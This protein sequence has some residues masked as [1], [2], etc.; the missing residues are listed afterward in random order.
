MPLALF[1]R[2]I[3]KL[4]WNYYLFFCTGFTV[5]H[6]TV[7]H[8]EAPNLIPPMHLFIHYLLD[9][10]IVSGIFFLNWLFFFLLYLSVYLCTGIHGAGTHERVTHIRAHK[11]T[12]SQELRYSMGAVIHVCTVQYMV[13]TPKMN[14]SEKICTRWIEDRVWMHILYKYKSCMALGWFS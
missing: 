6:I 14:C 10:R 1:F 12:K 5:S 2:S 9:K 3:S 11:A 13:S 8:N 7:H 4:K